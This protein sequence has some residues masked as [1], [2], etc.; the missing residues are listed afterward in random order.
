MVTRKVWR[1]PRA[2][3]LLE[4][5]NTAALLLDAELRLRYLN[6][7]GET[8]LALS[9]RKARGLPLTQIT[10][11][12]VEFEHSLRSSLASGHPFTAHEMRISLHD[13]RAIT[14]DYS[15]TPIIE[16]GVMQGLL[17]E[18]NQ[19]DRQLR[20]AHEEHLLDQQ[21]IARALV[22]GLAHEI[23]NPLGGLRGAAQLLERELP[24]AALREYTRIIIGEADRL[25]GLVNRMLGPNSRLNLRPVSIHEALEHVRALIQAEAPA[26]SLQRDYDPSLPD[27]SA[28]RDMLVQA[29]LNVI[30]NAVEAVEGRGQITLRTR[31]ARQILIG[32][33]RHRL[34]ARIEVVD[35]GPGIPADLLEHIFYP[36]ITG[37]AQGTGLGLSIAQSIINQHGGLI[38]CQSQPG[39]TVFTLTLPLEVS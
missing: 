9:L 2:A 28:D 13:G 38:E 14:V 39:H 7:A 16:A 31:S 24:D 30:R 35:T 12:A 26:L 5:F 36:M 19:V 23:K 11:G 3:Q 4:H 29:L 22:R 27:L 33:R 10:H 6:P 8:L 21:Q 1:L 25:Q 17:V 15:V 37:K 20:I 18:M 34:V 32:K